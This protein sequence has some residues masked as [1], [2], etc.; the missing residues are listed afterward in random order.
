MTLSIASSKSISSTVYLFLLTATIADSLI[1]FLRSA[2][3]KPG[4]SS[5]NH[6]QVFSNDKSSLSEIFFKYK[7]MISSHSSKFGKWNSIILSSLP[8]L[9]SAGSNSSGML[10]DPNTII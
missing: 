2:D 10:V 3:E 5:A 6:L 9:K 8:G 7:E 4:V 1:I